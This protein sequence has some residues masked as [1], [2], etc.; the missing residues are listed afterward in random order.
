MPRNISILQSALLLSVG[1]CQNVPL[2]LKNENYRVRGVRGRVFISREV[3]N[4]RDGKTE[5]FKIHSHWF[6]YK[7]LS[8]CTNLWQTASFKIFFVFQSKNVYNGKRWCDQAIKQVIWVRPNIRF[9]DPPPHPFYHYWI[10][11]LIFSKFIIYN[12]CYFRV[13]I[14]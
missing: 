5:L 2:Y 8:V 4:Y 11:P 10:W 1:S 13:R 14:G 6:Y 3:W 9:M 12:L 7:A